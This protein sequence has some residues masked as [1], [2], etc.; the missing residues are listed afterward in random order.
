LLVTPGGASLADGDT[1]QL[2]DGYQTPTVFEF[3]NGT[4]AVGHI[5][6][7]HPA[8]TTAQEANL[9]VNAINGQG[10]TLDINASALNGGIISLSNTHLSVKGNTAIALSA[11]LASNSEWGTADM[12]GG[13]AGDCAANVGCQS[14]GDCASGNCNMGQH[15]C[16]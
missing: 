7:T 16:N 12:S 15:K 3:N 1:F 4:A 10:G 9:I 6:I 11:S 13:A 5:K 14:N 2:N 8:N